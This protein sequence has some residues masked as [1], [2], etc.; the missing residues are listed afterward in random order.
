MK[1]YIFAVLIIPLLS[2]PFI[3]F[4][5]TCPNGQPAPCAQSDSTILANGPQGLVGLIE[6]IG[7]WLF[8]FLL[9]LAVV[10]IVLA[11]YKYLFSQG[12]EEVSKAHKMLIYAAVAIAVAVLAKG[13]VAVVEKLVGGGAT[14]AGSTSQ[15]VQTPAGYTAIAGAPAQISIQTCSDGKVPGIIVNNAH[16]CCDRTT[17]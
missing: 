3:S 2:A 8:T 16:G 7:D 1:K 6:T 13:I 10:F 9:V 17:K 4:A 14:P 5:L 11:A 15:T 12:G